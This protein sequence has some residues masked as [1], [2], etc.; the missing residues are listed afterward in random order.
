MLILSGV[1]LCVYVYVCFVMVIQQ[2]FQ[3]MERTILWLFISTYF[4]SGSSFAVL[5]LM[6]VGLL[7]VSEFHVAEGHQQE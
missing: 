4:Y 5:V 1:C 2:R 7:S 6:S 3:S